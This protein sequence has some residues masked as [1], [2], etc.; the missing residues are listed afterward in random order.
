MFAYKYYFQD[1][2]FKKINWFKQT[3][4]QSHKDLYTY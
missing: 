1:N 4:K 2:Q 3:N